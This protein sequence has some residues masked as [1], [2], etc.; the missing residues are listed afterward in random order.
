[1][2]SYCIDVRCERFFADGEDEGDEVRRWASL[3][4]GARFRCDLRCRSFLH[5]RVW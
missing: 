3:G 5:R 4:P 1:M 2:L